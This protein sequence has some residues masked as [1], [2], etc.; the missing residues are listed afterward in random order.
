[1]L[2]SG[3]ERF[4]PGVIYISNQHHR[5]PLAEM[6]V[7]EATHQYAYILTRLG[8]LDDG[9]DQTLYYSPIRNA[10]RPIRF[11]VLAYHAFANVLLFYR[12]ARAH[13]LPDEE[14]LIN[15]DAP[16]ESHLETLEQALQ[17]TSALTCF[18]R[19]LWEP[20]YEQIHS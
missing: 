11:I 20:L 4:S 14:V 6:L 17:R 15:G 18:G 7:H 19:A 12:M 9:T 2:N 8:P 3:S 16:L 1:M 5:C 10:G 13:G